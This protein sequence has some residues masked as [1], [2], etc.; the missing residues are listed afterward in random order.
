MP[1]L[2]GKHHDRFLDWFLENDRMSSIKKGA[3]F[4]FGFRTNGLVFGMTKRLR[5]DVFEDDF[6]V[7]GFINEVNKNN[8]YILIENSN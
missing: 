5:L 3:I 6:G 4:N 2:I 7:S 1:V 8:D